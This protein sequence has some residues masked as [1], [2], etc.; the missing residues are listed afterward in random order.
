M[1][2]RNRSVSS[3][4]A[5]YDVRLIALCALE[6]NLLSTLDLSWIPKSAKSDDEGKNF[7]KEQYALSAALK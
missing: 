4:A 5:R 6:V 3:F 7:M 2:I 1:Q